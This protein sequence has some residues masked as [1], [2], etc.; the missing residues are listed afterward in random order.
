MLVDLLVTALVYSGPILIVRYLILK[1]TIAVSYSLLVT[2]VY[3]IIGYFLFRL[4]FGSAT[5]GVVVIWSIINFN[6]LSR[7]KTNGKEEANKR[8]RI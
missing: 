3:G 5:L 4:L 6:I 7:W 1:K 8:T 2:V